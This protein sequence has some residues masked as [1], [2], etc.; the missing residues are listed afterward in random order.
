MKGQVFNAL[1]DI[2]NVYTTVYKGLGIFEGFCVDMAQAA[3]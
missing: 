2:Y 1:R 3:A